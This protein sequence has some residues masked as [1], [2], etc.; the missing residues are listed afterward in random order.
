MGRKHAT[1]QYRFKPRLDRRRL[2]RGAVAIWVGV[3]IVAF[4]AA[5][6]LSIDVGRLYF[7][8]RNLQKTATL[9]AISAAQIASGCTNGDGIRVDPDQMFSQVQALVVANGGQAGWLSGFNGFE[10]IEVG[11]TRT[12][13]AGLRA[14]Q[15]LPAGDERINS[16]RVNLQRPAPNSFV[17]S[18]L[19]NGGGTLKASSTAEQRVLGSFY[20]GSG[21]ADLD[22]G[23]LN[24]LLGALLG[25]NINL[26]V[27]DFRS[28]AATQVTLG[29]LATALNVRVTDLSNLTE[30]GLDTPLLPDLLGGL[31]GGLG[32]TASGA[33]SGLLQQLAGAAR[34]ETV[35][36]GVLLGPLTDVAGNVP[37]INLL[38]LIMALGTAATA[39]GDPYANPIVVPLNVDVPGVAKVS[40]F[41]KVLEPPVFGVGAPGATAKTAQVKLA[42]RIEGGQL[43]TS[44]TQAISGVLGST[45]DFVTGLLRLLTLGLVDPRISTPVIKPLNLG[46][47]VN[48]AQAAARLDEIACPTA[49][50]PFPVARLSVSPAIATVHVGGFV[51]TPSANP[52][53]IPAL[54]LN[55][56]SVDVFHQT[57]EFRGLLSF[58]GGLSIDVGLDLSCVSV[59][60]VCNGPS[61]PS[62]GPFRPLPNDI[63]SFE[64]KVD[65][66]N[67]IARARTP[68]YL[69][70]G[71]P[72]SP[73]VAGVNPQTVGT[74][75]QLSLNLALRPITSPLP[76]TSNSVLGQ[77]A[78]L[79]SGLQSAVQ[80]LVSGLLNFVNNVLLSAIVNPL[81]K[82][83]GIELGRATVIM[84]AVSVDRPARVSNC[85]PGAT[86]GG[87]ICPLPD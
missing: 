63:D 71:I 29:A 78:S 1:S 9:A 10:A 66:D 81:L 60:G 84:E 8:Q 56:A 48:V 54:D 65:G 37:F 24:A 18:I 3:S 12:N 33:V 40:I 62:T 83:L 22:A 69:A 67:P 41:L 45:L 43:L 46:I 52:S 6:F 11:Q 30:L 53:T 80:G 4:I 87:R 49:E 59:G 51:G 36:L 76:G 7:T 68:Y 19:T 20:I 73:E 14:F 39:D 57:V 77:L 38:D 55:G 32:N 64:Y 58:L 23:L 17:P 61:A 42:V 86:T 28:L 82:L 34:N 50:S 26:S 25:S 44:L 27:A 5:T 79:V 15:A 75:P 13:S 16:V 2:Q 31:V 47:D 85:L 70:N 21:L 72:P 74:D 35:P